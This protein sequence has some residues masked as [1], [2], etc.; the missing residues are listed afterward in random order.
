MKKKIF[1]IVLLFALNVFPLSEVFA[2]P[3]YCVTAFVDCVSECSSLFGWFPLSVV[4][5]S[6]GCAIGY[7]RCGG[8]Q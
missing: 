8:A 4:G 1:Y 3:T 6:I 5:C 2:K 7:E